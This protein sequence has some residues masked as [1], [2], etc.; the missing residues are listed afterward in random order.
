MELVTGR[1]PIEAEYGEDKDIVYW[2]TRRMS[3]RESVAAVVDGRIPERAREEAVKVL[4]VAALCTARLPA[5][6]P[7]MRTVVQMLEEAASGRAL[8]A[9]ISKGEKA[10][11]GVCMAEGKRVNE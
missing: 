11:L 6:R 9:I 10:E 1:Q 8:A 7:S 3:S 5:M 4:R 2:V